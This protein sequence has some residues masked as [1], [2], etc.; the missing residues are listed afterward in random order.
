MEGCIPWALLSGPAQASK[1]GS[2]RLPVDTKPGLPPEFKRATP[3]RDITPAHIPVV[4]N[5]GVSMVPQ[6]GLEPARLSTA[7]FESAASTI[8]PLGQRPVNIGAARR[9]STR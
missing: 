7:D 8:S 5:R 6:A 3:G 9:A 1:P 2:K 4:A